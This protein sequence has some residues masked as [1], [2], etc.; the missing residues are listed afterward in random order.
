MRRGLGDLSWGFG[1]TSG[2]ERSVEREWSLSHVGDRCIG[3][4]VLV[5]EL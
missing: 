5:S 2:A 3:L 4:T 1:M